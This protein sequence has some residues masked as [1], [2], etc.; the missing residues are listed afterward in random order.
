VVIVLEDIHWADDSS[1]EIIEQLGRQAAR[2]RMLVACLARPNLFERCPQWGETHP[3]LTLVE[4]QPLSTPESRQLVMDILRK[5]EHIPDAL[6]ELV[7]GGAEGNPFFIEELIKLLIEDGVIVTDEEHWRVEPN[8]LAQIRIPQTLTG[9]LQARLDSLSAPE[10]AVIQQAA[11]V[12]RIFW[13]QAIFSIEAP[14]PGATPTEEAAR[15]AALAKALETLCR[16]ELIF[17]QPVSTFAGANEYSFKHALL[18]NVTY[19]SVLKRAR[20]Q[21]H[22]RVANWLMVRRPISAGQVEEFPGQPAAA[23]GSGDAAQPALHSGQVFAGLVADHLERAGRTTEAIAYLDQAGEEAARR[24]ANPEAIAYFN[25]ALA[26]L[27]EE[28]LPARYEL[29]IQR[30]TVYNLLGNSPACLADLDLLCAIAAELGDARRQAQVALRQMRFYNRGD[31][32]ATVEIAPAALA[33]AQAAKDQE[34]EAEILFAWGWALCQQ[35]HTETA[36]S[37][38]EHALAL[39]QQAG[40]ARLEGSCLRTLGILCNQRGDTQQMFDYYQRALEK[41]RQAGDRRGELSALNNLGVN[42]PEGERRVAY[43]EEAL[44]IAQAIGERFYQAVVLANLGNQDWARGSFSRAVERSQQA[45]QLAQDIQAQVLESSN[46]T[47]RADYAFSLGNYDACR[48]L[49]AQALKM[50]H[51]G[52]LGSTE[53]AALAQQIYLDA[54]LGDQAALR[55]RCAQLLGI[56]EKVER[57]HSKALALRAL[58][59]AYSSLGEHDQA[60]EYS[61]QALES[62]DEHPDVLLPSPTWKQHAHALAAAGRLPEARAAYQKALDTRLPWQDQPFEHLLRGCEAQA[63]L[64][65]LALQSGDQPQALA[66]VEQALELAHRPMPGSAGPAPD[67][68]CPPPVRAERESAL[69]TW[70][71]SRRS[72]P[73]ECARRAAGGAQ[74]MLRTPARS[75]LQ[76]GA[77]LTCK[78]SPT[79]PAAAVVLRQIKPLFS[80]NPTP[81]F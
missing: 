15:Q 39:A 56:W 41:H 37:Q 17:K 12:G 70:F 24:Y 20:R 27:P 38:V 3:C 31:L 26:L 13:D 30:Q 9:L 69:F 66:H 14:R 32:S 19:E 33:L 53:V 47:T 55:Q 81:S 44:G 35:G 64:A 75:A 40:M 42:L 11:I 77:A 29:L 45:S 8:R 1:L 2:Q 68:L 25:R 59:W 34:C 73:P 78:T 22:S 7:V 49:C 4:L 23:S 62:L 72:T 21:Y 67:S 18:H 50:A 5:T 58:S 6:R 51:Q 36:L 60:L 61:R 43:L 76:N 80:D 63:G 46:L 16:K 48:E 79:P 10:R 65:R 74:A 54:A 52:D 71:A 28:N 57:V